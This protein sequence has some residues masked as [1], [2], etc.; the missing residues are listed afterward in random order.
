MQK[1]MLTAKKERMERLI[2]SIDRILKGD[3][4]MDFAIFDRKEI[5]E[6]FRQTYERMPE[7]IRQLAV[8]EFGGVEEWKKHF[9]QL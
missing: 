9:W 8:D 3:N 7:K 4:K 2:V 6:M 1:E 5:E